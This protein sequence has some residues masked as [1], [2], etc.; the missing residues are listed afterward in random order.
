MGVLLF[1]LDQMSEPFAVA[2]GNLSGE[3]FCQMEVALG[4]LQMEMSHINGELGQLVGDV[5]ARLIPPEKPVN[6]ERMTPMTISS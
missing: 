6:G 4:T 3:L 1:S 2:A 5:G